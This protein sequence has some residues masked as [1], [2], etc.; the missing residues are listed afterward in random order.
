M[1]LVPCIAVFWLKGTEII[2][3]INSYNK[4]E[5]ILNLDKFGPIS[6]ETVILVIQVHRI[7]DSLKYLI[8]SLS[9]LNGIEDVLIIFSHSYFDDNINR[10]IESIDFC[11]V[12]QIFYTL[13]IQVFTHEFPGYSRNDC[14][15]DVNIERAE[16]LNCTGASTPDIHG[17]YR[18]PIKAE[19]K[20]HWWW[21]AN[22]IFE[23]LLCTNGHNGLVVFLENDLYLLNDFLYMVIYMRKISESLP[24]SAFLSLGSSLTNANVY[25][26]ELTTWDPKIHSDV[27]AFDVTVWNR[28]INN[29]NLFCDVDDSSWSRSL[30]YLSL[31][32][33]YN[34]RFKV[35]HT[36]VPRAM[37]IS[38]Y[39]LNVE[40]NVDNIISKQK[41]F[42]PNLF[43]PYLE[44]YTNI[45]L[46]DDEYVIFDLI[47]GE[48]GWNDPRDILLYKG[49]TS[50]ETCDGIA[51]AAFDLRW[52]AWEGYWRPRLRTQPQPGREQQSARVSRH[53]RLGYITPR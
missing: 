3:L 44:I 6:H 31:N 29:Y 34:R 21:T 14:P 53:S 7:C 16:F 32:Q 9:E 15:Y 19:K 8:A 52:R 35:L 47:V 43:P 2:S 36:M 11:R 20:H 49:E 24:Q 27:L 39:P 5:K 23:K 22:T 12:L 1:N 18:H 4:D 30:L 46:E 13:S 45:E 25:S 41:T 26:I 38:V 40:N 50:A 42:K 48:G 51:L 10:L 33:K 28:I 37:K 17:K